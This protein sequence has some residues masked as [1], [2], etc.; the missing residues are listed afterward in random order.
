MLCVSGVTSELDKVTFGVRQGSVLGPLLF[1]I[2]ANDHI[3]QSIS[4][5]NYVQMTVTC[6]KF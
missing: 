4:L 5:L 3:G 2:Y 6:L 1:L